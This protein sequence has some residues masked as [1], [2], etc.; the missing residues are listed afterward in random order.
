MGKVKEKLLVEEPV[1][2]EPVVEEPVVEEPVVEEMLIVEEDD[3]PPHIVKQDEP[4]KPK[5]KQVI[6][7]GVVVDC[8]AL[9]LREGASVKSRQ[10][11]IM[12]VGTVVKVDLDNSTES[13]Y[14]VSHTTKDLV[15]VGYCLKE[16]IK[17]G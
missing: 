2:E 4:A 1:V 17:V 6:V 11:A 7:D 10:L 14:E 5:K 9:R 8:N 12:P 3:T 16:Y 13:F 15:L